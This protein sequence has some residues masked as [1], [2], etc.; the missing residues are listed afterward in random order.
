MS[1]V[2]SLAILR[3]SLLVWDSTKAG[4]DEKILVELKRWLVRRARKAQ[5]KDLTKEEEA[6]VACGEFSDHMI[7]LKEDKVHA[8]NTRDHE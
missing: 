1:S 5:V 3:S 7:L 8:R 6:I 2:I 4:E